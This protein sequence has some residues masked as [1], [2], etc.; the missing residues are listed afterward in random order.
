MLSWL[1]DAW[2]EIDNNESS[3]I[4]IYFRF[5]KSIPLDDNPIQ[6]I[7]FS[8][9]PMLCIAETKAFK[10]TSIFAFGMTTKWLLAPRLANIC[11]ELSLKWDWIWKL[12]VPPQVRTFCGVHAMTLSQPRWLWCEDVYDR[13]HFVLFALWRRNIFS[14]ITHFSIRSGVKSHSYYWVWY[15]LQTCCRVYDGYVIH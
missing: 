14:L 2:D 5:S 6:E 4:P 15:Q 8:C 3:C 7:G 13:T 9:K 11:V 10:A 12:P 1:G